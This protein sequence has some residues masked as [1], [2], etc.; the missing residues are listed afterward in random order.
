MGTLG[1]IFIGIAF[2]GP[3]SAFITGFLTKAS[4]KIS[5]GATWDAV[6]NATATLIP[7]AVNA[8]AGA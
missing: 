6:F 1:G 4:E 5:D 8:T 7:K 2:A 3:I